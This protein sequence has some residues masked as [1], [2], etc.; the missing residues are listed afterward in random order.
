MALGEDEEPRQAV[1]D[2]GTN[3][4]LDS[5][6]HA[7][8]DDDEWEDEPDDDASVT[9][10]MEREQ[11]AAFPRSQDYDDEAQVDDVFPMDA[12]Q[13]ESPN[14]DAMREA[15]NRYFA[16]ADHNRHFADQ[17]PEVP[18]ASSATSV[19][20]EP[21]PQP[22][23]RS[24]FTFNFDV[25]QV[26]RAG[27]SGFGQ[28][29]SGGNGAGPAGAP[30]R[31]LWLGR[32]ADLP[33]SRLGNPPPLGQD[34]SA[35]MQQP[36]FPPELRNRA[37]GPAAAEAPPRREGRARQAGARERARRARRDHEEIVQGVEERWND[38]EGDLDGEGEG[39][40][41][42]LEGDIDGA[43]EGEPRSTI[44]ETPGCGKLTLT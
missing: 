12:D 1:S 20:G 19:L 5:P 17:A 38:F 32:E 4:P 31:P 35:A 28:Q 6:G 40:G 27:P 23:Y 30:Q 22:S 42:I 36:I 33:P 25:G 41:F 43:M 15:R 26:D 11:G 21:W 18:E 39:E 14:L 34:T 29:Q 9:A 44:L 10:L 7:Q 37:G 2:A 8:V 16:V 3:T 13:P 24:D